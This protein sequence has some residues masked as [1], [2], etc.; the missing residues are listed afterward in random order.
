M[1]PAVTFGLD[2]AKWVFRFDGVGAT[3]DVVRQRLSGQGASIQAIWRKFRE[4]LGRRLRRP[5]HGSEIFAN[6]FHPCPPIRELRGGRKYRS[7]RT[8]TPNG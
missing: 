2:I 1:K 6:G 4:Y 8:R 3:G 7:P 5:G